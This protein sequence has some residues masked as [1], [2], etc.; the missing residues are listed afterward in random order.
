MTE[1][2][3]KI[4]EV[5]DTSVMCIDELLL[6]MKVWQKELDLRGRKVDKQIQYLCEA[7]LEIKKVLDPFPCLSFTFESKYA[8]SDSSSDIMV[9]LRAMEKYLWEISEKLSLLKKFVMSSWSSNRILALLIPIRAAKVIVKSYNVAI[10]ESSRSPRKTPRSLSKEKRE[11][12]EKKKERDSR[13]KS[14]RIK[15]CQSN[16]RVSLT[17]STS[18]SQSLSVHERPEERV[19]LDYELDFAEDSDTMSMEKE[20]DTKNPLRASSSF[21]SASSHNS[22]REDNKELFEVR[23][24]TPERKHSKDKTKKEGRRN[25][26]D[27]ENIRLGARRRTISESSYTG[28]DIPLPAGGKE[29]PIKRTTSDDSVAKRQSPVPPNLS[30]KSRSDVGPDTIRAKGK[31]DTFT[32]DEINKQLGDSIPN[33]PESI[34]RRHSSYAKEAKNKKSTKKKILEAISPFASAHKK[35]QLNPS[36]SSSSNEKSP[37]SVTQRTSRRKSEVGG[38]RERKKKGAER[39]LEVNK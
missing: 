21:S 13:T 18:Q 37:A 16:D 26:K 22:T 2:D 31:R 4:E 8:S 34:G 17:G 10:N 35:K 6:T 12:V 28:D 38:V 24:G 30:V 39:P 11:S 3:K 19:T 14:A 29:T 20:K 5:R 27:A 15:R 7:V 32:M 33:T 25:Q 36:T 9:F 23:K 1:E